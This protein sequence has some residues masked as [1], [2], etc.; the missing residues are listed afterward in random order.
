M[1]RAQR[2]REARAARAVGVDVELAA[3]PAGQLAPDRE[4]EPEA[5]GR[6][7]G[8]AAVEALEDAVAFLRRDARAWSA[9]V[10]TA[11]PAPECAATST[12]APRGP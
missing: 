5:A 7:R 6:A 3:H 2:Q 4:P 12:G 9:T 8:G 10:I 11:R 1:R